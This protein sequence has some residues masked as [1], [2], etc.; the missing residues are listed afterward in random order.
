MQNQAVQV[1]SCNIYSRSSAIL[2]RE[3]PVPQFHRLAFCC[4]QAR[5]RG[6]LFVRRS[7]FAIPFAIIRVTPAKWHRKGRVLLLPGR[8]DLTTLAFCR[9]AVD[10]MVQTSI[11]ASSR[12]ASLAPAVLLPR[13]LHENPGISVLDKEAIEND[14]TTISLR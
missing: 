3:G 5:Q 2:T 10:N 13:V 8:P 12:V 6:D 4:H 7:K 11:L 14:L 1:I 9:K